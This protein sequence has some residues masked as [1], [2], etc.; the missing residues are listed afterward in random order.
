MNE[1]NDMND[2]LETEL[3]GTVTPHTDDWQRI[4][5]GLAARAAG[6]GLLDVSYGMHDSPYG[7][8]LVGVTPAGLVRIGLS[9]E[10]E[11]DILEDIARRLSPR[12]MKAT[13]P[14]IDLARTQLDQ[15]F[16]GNRTRFDIPLDWRLVTGFRREVLTATENIPYG[17]TRSY[18]EMAV[19]A[20]SPRAVRA[21]GTALAKNP[22]PIVVPCHRVLR[23][24]GKVG[25]YLG[26]TEMKRELLE[27]E[28]RPA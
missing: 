22:L 8:L 27:M 28:A 26:G 11:E 15:Y 16:E 21:A 4:R 7:E 17:E 1:R 5:S 19:E 23:T 6:E 13:D 14:A 12:V 2:Q 24:D 3:S 20:G 10:S 25:A 18:R 9:A